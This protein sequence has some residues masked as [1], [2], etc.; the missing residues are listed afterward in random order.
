M[1]RRK[2]NGQKV[3]IWGDKWI[4]CPTSF[5]AQ[6]PLNLLSN[7]AKVHELIS[8]DTFTWNQD[9][10]AQI[11]KVDEAETIYK[12]SLCLFGALDKLIWWPAKKNAFSVKFA[13]FL[14]MKDRTL[15]QGESSNQ[16]TKEK[17]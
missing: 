16:D 2:G 4:P 3:R 6:S 9:L 12:I 14:E 13:Y 15:N 1:F 8:T 11:F 17:F 10:I 5:Q 7:D